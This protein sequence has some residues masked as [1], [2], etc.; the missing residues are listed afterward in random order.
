[1]YLVATE[2]VGTN[3]V[4]VNSIS[5]EVA[6]PN[7][8]FCDS[9]IT[10]SATPEKHLSDLEDT[11][12]E[13]SSYQVQLNLDWRPAEIE[14]GSYIQ[15]A[16]ESLGSRLFSVYSQFDPA[17]HGN[18]IRHL[19]KLPLPNNETAFLR[20]VLQSETSVLAMA[21]IYRELIHCHRFSGSDGFLWPVISGDSLP[22]SSW[23]MFR[24]LLRDAWW[25]TVRLHISHNSPEH[26]F[27]MA[28]ITRCGFATAP[29]GKTEDMDEVGNITLPQ[30]SESDGVYNFYRYFNKLRRYDA[31]MPIVVNGSSMEHWSNSENQKRI[32][33]FISLLNQAS[34]A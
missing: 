19:L 17:W 32:E 8:V 24:E 25:D 6:L 4:R 10:K 21:A 31:N 23:R 16:S 13:L 20:I 33:H 5:N 2:S 22:I 9:L 26:V 30:G 29:I 12:G 15:R 11:I 1:M 34:K 7:T 27:E 14:I 18:A 28:R 3:V